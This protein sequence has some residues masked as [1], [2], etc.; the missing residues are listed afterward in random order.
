MSATE[1]VAHLVAEGPVA[2]VTDADFR[3][4]VQAVADYAIF[5]LDTDGRIRSWNEGARRLKG[6]EADEIIGRSFETFYPEDAIH[7][8]FP[9][10]ELREALRNGRFEDEGWRLRK[11]GSRFWASVIIT[12]LFD[13][14]GRHRGFAKVTRDLTERRTQEDALRRSEERFRLL[15]DSVRDYAI[16]LLDNDGRVISWNL[17]AELTKG[18]L[19]EEI[20]GRHFSVFYPQEK[21]DEHWPE[22]ELEVARRDGRFEDEG[23]RLR[24]DGSRFW[25]SVVITALYDEA[26]QPKGFAKITRDLTDR[27]R[28]SDL[29]AQERHLTQF[30]AVLGH[31]LRNP[32]TPIANAV[33]IMQLEEPTNPRIR[34]ARDILARQVGHLRRLVDDLLDVGRI[35]SGKVHLEARPVELRA[36]LAEAAESIRPEMKARGHAFEVATPPEDLWVVGDRTRLVQVLTN[37]LHN[38][39]KFTPSGGHVWL[40][41]ARKDDQAEL[42]V[43]DN[44]PGIPPDQLPRMFTLFAQAEGPISTQSHGGLGI[45]L[46]LVKQ[47]VALHHGDIRAASSGVPGEG[48]EFVVSLPLIDPPE[49]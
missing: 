37:L 43:R 27:R 41:L 46:S 10:Y 49:A 6:Y 15:V 4:L 14:E 7:R 22:R 25:A 29:E 16:F 40:S 38:A 34:T 21:R 26:G 47:M 12:A 32:M 13:E 28:I 19:A 5:L 35:A 1:P 8:R 17:G 18:Y 23:W 33:A 39:A 9:Q 3:L 2:P 36:L 11:D 20:V 44:G 45:G 31:E 24:K 48:A 42:A 30:L